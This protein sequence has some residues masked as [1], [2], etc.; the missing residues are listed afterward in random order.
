M[1][2]AKRCVTLTI[3]KLFRPY[4]ST[5]DSES[6]AVLLKTGKEFA[7]NHIR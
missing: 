1:Q 4:F 3:D 5:Q 6:F 2:P 7:E